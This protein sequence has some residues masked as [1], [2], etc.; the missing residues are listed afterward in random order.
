MR[1]RK[2]KAGVI[3]EETSQLSRQGKSRK[4]TKEMGKN[5]TW[6]QNKQKKE[7]TSESEGA[8]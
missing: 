1:A 5:I 3:F 4:A 6:N 8:V 7:R 2:R